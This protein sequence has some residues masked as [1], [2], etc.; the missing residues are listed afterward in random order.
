MSPLAG[1]LSASASESQ[2]FNSSLLGLRLHL[3]K[4]YN[5][6]KTSRLGEYLELFFKVKFL[7]FFNV[8]W[9]MGGFITYEQS[10]KVKVPFFL[11]SHGQWVGLYHTTHML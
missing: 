9:S 11:I 3:A 2:I 5:D 10:F 4:H 8:T 1:P 6:L 7:F